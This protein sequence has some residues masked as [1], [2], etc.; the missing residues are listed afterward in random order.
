M[1][2]GGKLIGRFYLTCTRAR[3]YEHANVVPLRQGVSGHVPL[4]GLV[5]NAPDGLMEHSDVVTFLHEYGHLL[6]GI[7][8]GQNQRWAGQSGIA[9]EADFSEAPSQMLEEWVY[10]YDTLK[11]FATDDAGK[12]IPQELVAQMNRARHFDIG[13]GNMR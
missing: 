3:Q 10:D 9:T 5:M 6:H 7:F 12:P 13:M 11:R 1:F 4:I 8:G 2:E